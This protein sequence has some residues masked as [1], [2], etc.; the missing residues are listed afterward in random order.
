MPL[1]SQ[2]ELTSQTV[3]LGPSLEYLVLRISD[4]YVA[5]PILPG[6]TLTACAPA[7]CGTQ[8]FVFTVLRRGGQQD[9]LKLQSL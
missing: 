7:P 1:P 3:L 5:F 4:R 6:Q 9:T 2:Q 8:D